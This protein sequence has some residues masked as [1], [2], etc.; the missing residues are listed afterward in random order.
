MVLGVVVLHPLYSVDPGDLIFQFLGLVLRNIRHHNLGTAISD[1]LILHDVQG[2]PGLRILRQIGRQFTLH[3]HP[4][5][6]KSRENQH[7]DGK[8]E[9]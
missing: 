8:Q 3:L 5:A 1:E 6:G 9:K 7:N 2:L 4:V